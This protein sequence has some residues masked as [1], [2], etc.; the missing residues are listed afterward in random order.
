M[1]AW[2]GFGFFKS[3]SVTQ[4]GAICLGLNIVQNRNSTKQNNG[5]YI[6][7]DGVKVLPT[8]VIANI[9]PDYSDTFNTD[10]QNYTGPQY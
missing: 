9:D 5:T 3:D 2:I 1:P 10:F 4:G 7:G 8:A 6:I